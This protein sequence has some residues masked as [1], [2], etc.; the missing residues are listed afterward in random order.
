M[1]SPRF[2]SDFV[3][4]GQI[5][6]TPDSG[7]VNVGGYSLGYGED[8][9]WVEV[10]QVSPDGPWPFS[11][12]ILGFATTYGNELGTIKI[13]PSSTS[14]LYKLSVGLPPS[15]QTGV[16]TCEPRSYNLSWVRTGTPWSL[17][18]SARS[19]QSHGVPGDGPAFGTRAT[20]GVLADL[21][22][23]G[24]SYSFGDDAARV[25]LTDKN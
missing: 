19:G 12:G 3:Q 8:T 16:I 21:L 13:F 4:I 5:T 14:S 7:V 25:R 24:V 11:F 2:P 22:S 18:F 17:N 6:V 9:I 10:Q 23:R 15:A 20:L 1:P